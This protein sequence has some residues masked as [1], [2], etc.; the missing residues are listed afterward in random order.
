MDRLHPQSWRELRGLVQLHG[1]D[2]IR[3]AL[4][5][6]EREEKPLKSVLR[7]TVSF[8][9]YRPYSPIG[10]REPIPLTLPAGLRVMFLPDPE[11]GRWVLDEFPVSLFPINSIER[12]DAEHH[13]ITVPTEAVEAVA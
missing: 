9:W 2:A 4:R 10:E 1:I 3:R 7:R 12:H 11:G 5:D 13:G 6:L 8:D